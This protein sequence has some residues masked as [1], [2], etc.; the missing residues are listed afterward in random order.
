MLL[1]I[2]ASIRIKADGK[3]IENSTEASVPENVVSS[4]MP[5]VLGEPEQ[6]V[7][8][9]TL[10]FGYASAPTVTSLVSSLARFIL[11]R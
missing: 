2:D 8:L 5:W 1:G 3:T 7:R 10:D 11:P 9:K 4:L 6:D